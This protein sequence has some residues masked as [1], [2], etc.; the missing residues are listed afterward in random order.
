[1]RKTRTILPQHCNHSALQFCERSLL[2]AHFFTVQWWFLFSL[3]LKKKKTAHHLLP[4]SQ[5]EKMECVLFVFFFWL[6]QA[7]SCLSTSSHRRDH[8]Y[9]I[10]C[11]IVAYSNAITVFD[12]W[13]VCHRFAVVISIRF[14]SKTKKKNENGNRVCINDLFIVHWVL[15]LFRPMRIF[16][17]LKPQL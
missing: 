1:M 9:L 6:F 17:L 12:V 16:H 8:R 3:K 5:T 15:L 4:F 2:A 11:M 13:F 10:K 7:D 14:S